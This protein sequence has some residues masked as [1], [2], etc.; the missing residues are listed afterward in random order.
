[1]LKE[2]TARLKP[3]PPFPKFEALRRPARLLKKVRRRSLEV[4]QNSF[5]H[6]LLLFFFLFGVFLVYWCETYVQSS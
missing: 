3:E 4:A 6:F 5:Q 2:T 1:M